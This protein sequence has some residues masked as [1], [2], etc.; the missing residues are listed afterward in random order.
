MEWI[1]RVGRFRMIT[2]FYFALLRDLGVGKA[3]IK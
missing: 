3:F 1:D 2:R